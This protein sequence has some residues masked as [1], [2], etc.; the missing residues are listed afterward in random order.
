MTPAPLTLGLALYLGVWLVQRTLELLWSRRNLQRVL[1]RGAREYGAAHFPYFVVLHATYPLA[2]T[3][4]V[5]SDAAPGPFWPVWL[6]VW[7]VAQVLRASAIHA[8][9]DRWN[10]RIVVV[11]GEAPVRRGIYRWFRHPNYLAVLLEFIAAPLMFGA[12][13]T[14][15]AFSLLNALAL[16]VRIPVEERALREANEAP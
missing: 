7:L 3:A 12:W 9:G 4:E 14:A 2:L 13:R 6:V 15:V 1:E 11:P 8:L 10:V 5:F 16:R